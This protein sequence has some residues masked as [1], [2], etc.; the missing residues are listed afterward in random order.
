MDRTDK[1]TDRAA[2]IVDRTDKV[3]DR[4]AKIVDRTDKIVDRTQSDGKIRSDEKKS[5][6]VGLNHQID[7]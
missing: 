5:R 1:V 7:G 6:S 3:T 2:K 4:A